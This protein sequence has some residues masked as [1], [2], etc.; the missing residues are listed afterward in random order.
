MLTRTQVSDTLET[1]PEQ[2]SLDQ[3]FDKLLFINKV[4]IGLV[5]SEQ[6]QVNTKEQARQKLSKW[7]K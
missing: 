2:F 3:L 7:L 1:M 5:Q 4:E 6:G